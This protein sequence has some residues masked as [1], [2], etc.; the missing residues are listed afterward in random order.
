M[1]V[2]RIPS[3]IVYHVREQTSFQPKRQLEKD[4]GSGKD[5]LRGNFQ[6]AS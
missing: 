6:K 5:I 1:F 4:V 3:A 2:D